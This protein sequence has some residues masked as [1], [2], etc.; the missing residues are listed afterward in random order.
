MSRCHDRG[1]ETGNDHGKAREGGMRQYFG[2]G[3]E[4]EYD[5]VKVREEVS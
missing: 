4:T 3:D 1:R 5:R 2:S